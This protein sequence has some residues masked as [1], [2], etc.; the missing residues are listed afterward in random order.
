MPSSTD[1]LTNDATPTVSGS[2]GEAGATVTLYDTNG[3]TALG[4]VTAD[5][6]GNWSITSSA[7]GDGAHTLRAKQTDLAGTVSVASAGPVVTVDTVEAAPSILTSTVSAITGTAG[8]GSA[9]TLFDGAT[10][11]GTAVANSIGTWSVPIALAAGTHAV[12]G[13]A[14]DAAGNISVPSPAINHHGDRWRRYSG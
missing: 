2:G 8:A 13:T 1:N 4:S 10:M 3:T 11:I 6:A 5:V 9:V 7:L 12:T 14:A